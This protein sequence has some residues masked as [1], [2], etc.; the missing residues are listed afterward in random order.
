M[1][2]LYGDDI[3]LAAAEAVLNLAQ[4]FYPYSGRD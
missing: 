4:S 1:N 3:F 2:A